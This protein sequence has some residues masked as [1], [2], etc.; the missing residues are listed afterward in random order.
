MRK[1][2]VLLCAAFLLV[3][4]IREV[5]SVSERIKALNLLIGLELEPEQIQALKRAIDEKKSLRE[6][7][8]KE[9]EPVLAEYRQVLE[10]IEKQLIEKGRLDEETKRRYRMLHGQLER[11]QIRLRREELAIARSFLQVLKPHQIAA[12]ENYVPCIIPPEKGLRVGQATD[13]KRL[14][15]MLERLRE[16]P[17][18]RWDRVKYRIARRM[19][20]KD[21]KVKRGIYPEE[22]LKAK[23]EKIA[24]KLEEIRNMPQED[25]LV[26][27]EKLAEELHQLLK[28]E[29]RKVNL[30]FTVDRFLLKKEVKDLLEKM[31]RS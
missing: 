4:A 14:V 31:G 16:I 19:L 17:D 18:A 25:F 13:K 15:Q 1:I 23:E 21:P 26:Q 12:L 6:R 9:M 10:E 29:R 28:G 5:E 11:A 22:E 8:L 30:E 3:G 27:K 20:I 24:E 2:A 7:F